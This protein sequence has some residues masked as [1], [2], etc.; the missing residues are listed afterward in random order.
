MIMTGLQEG[1]MKMK[2]KI[3]VKRISETNT[4]QNVKIMKMKIKMKI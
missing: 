2:T 1:N 3:V 4:I